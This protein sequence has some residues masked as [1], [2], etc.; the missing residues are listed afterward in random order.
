[1]LVCCHVLAFVVVTKMAEV[2]FRKY[3]TTTTTT[4]YTL[5]MKCFG[6]KPFTFIIHTI[7]YL[8]LLTL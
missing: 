5:E 8:P 2:C 1:M 6:D 7:I 3:F 4:T